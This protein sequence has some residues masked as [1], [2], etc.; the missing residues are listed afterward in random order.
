M[1]GK[2]RITKMSGGLIRGKL[3]RCSF[4]AI[5]FN[6]ACKALYDRLVAKDKNGKAALIAV[7]NKPLALSNPAYPTKLISTA[8]FSVV[9]LPQPTDFSGKT[10]H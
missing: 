2:V 8:D 5:K 6:T 4:T 1:R 9:L 7:C 10:I 3:F